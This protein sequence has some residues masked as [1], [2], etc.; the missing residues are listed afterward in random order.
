MR[1]T[2]FPHRREFSR[3]GRR[4]QGAR[5]RRGVSLLEAILA[6]A[7]LGASLAVL[8]Q[9]FENGVDAGREAGELS[10]CRT[11][12]ARRMNELM[13]EVDGGLAPTTAIDVPTEDFQLE[14]TRLLSHDVEVAPGGIDGLLSIRITVR[15]LDPDDQSVR[16]TYSLTRWVVDPALGLE[17]LEAEMMAAQSEE[18]ET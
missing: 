14:S 9:I 2:A 15:S 18:E 13:L 4:D 12:A 6:L 11:V 16:A 17:A 5:R 10:A 8:S 3:A 1:A 7:I